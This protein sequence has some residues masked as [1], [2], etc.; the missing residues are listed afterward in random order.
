MNQDV[1]STGGR[2]RGLKALLAGL[3]AA[4]A[5]FCTAA[6]HASTTSAL[7]FAYMGSAYG[8]SA[9]SGTLVTAG[10]SF[11]VAAP[12][13]V[14]SKCLAGSGG[15]WSNSGGG[16]SAPNKYQTGTTS[17]SVVVS[18][19]SSSGTTR[20]TSTVHSVNVLSGLVTAS[21]VDA[22]SQVTYSTTSGFS[23]TDGSRLTGVTVAGEAV[24]VR[25][26]TQ[27]SI[28]GLGYVA[29]DQQIRTE[30]SAATTQTI[31][32][33]RVVVTVA[34]NVYGLS[35]GT[36][37]IVGHAVATI[38]NPSVSAGVPVAGVAFG[39]RA[40]AGT[41]VTSDASAPAYLPCST[42][43]RSNELASETL[44]GIGSTGQIY[45]TMTLQ[46]GTTSTQANATS[47]VDSL[48]LL[49]GL[50]TA[51]VVKA[52]VTGTST[53]GL[54]SF[55]DGSSLAGLVV[56]GTA[57]SSTATGKI[58]IANLGTLYVH[59]VVSTATS[60]TVRMLELVVTQS[61]RYGLA[62]GTDVQVAVTR[63]TFT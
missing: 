49:H 19:D 18:K 16:S 8:T 25:P 28:P 41:S 40:A 59:R 9:Q 26:N 51:K 4:V 42:G 55:S 24:L 1:S 61:N 5:V 11:P 63:V 34:G 3:V 46:L 22:V 6:A 35:P 47:T 23:F 21:S 38:S 20:S 50:I 39:T 27:V 52:S 53:G 57:V 58:T 48:D 60:E 30:N 45:D 31:N 14:C 36:N 43:T 29:L 44:P 32:M 2:V 37:I 13:C 10:P 56:D 54:D 12:A 33:I 7:S 17:N 62:V 15:T